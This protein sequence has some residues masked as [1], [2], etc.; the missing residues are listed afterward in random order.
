MKKGSYYYGPTVAM[1]NKQK[2]DPAIYRT[3]L[4]MEDGCKGYFDFLA[5]PRYRSLKNCATDSD[6]LDKIGPCGWN[7]NIGY[8]DRC[9]KH[10]PDVY[11]ALVNTTIWMI[12]YTYTTQQDLNI[13]KEPNGD[14]A[15]IDDITENAKLNSFITP[16]G[17]IALK[18]N[19]RV[20]VKEIFND[21]NTTWLRIPSGWICGKNSKNIY[22]L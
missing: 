3:Y 6:Y 5:Y 2:T 10:L 12:G 19:T 21:N 14:F 1:D 16:H 18:R 8:G 20:T 11:N 9:K 17:N 15:S 13:R 4:T 7:S 22:V